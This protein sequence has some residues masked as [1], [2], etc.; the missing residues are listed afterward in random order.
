MLPGLTEVER[1]Q[2]FPDPIEV[3][4]KLRTKPLNPNIGP[5]RA[6]SFGHRPSSAS[7]HLIL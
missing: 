1:K 7:R 4:S 3:T 6:V 2:Y 5:G